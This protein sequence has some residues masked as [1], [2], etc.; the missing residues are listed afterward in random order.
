MKGEAPAAGGQPVLLSNYSCCRGTWVWGVQKSSSVKATGCH[1]PVIR[2]DHTGSQSWLQQLLG[3]PLGKL[4]YLA[5]LLGSNRSGVGGAEHKQPHPGSLSHAR[6]NEG[7]LL[8][9]PLSTGAEKKN[10]PGR[11]MISAR[12]CEMATTE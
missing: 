2:P 7:S 11:H 1:V 12:S 5:K 3:R 6:L 9:L 10:R 4:F 8:N